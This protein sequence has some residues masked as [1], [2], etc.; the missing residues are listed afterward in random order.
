ME[1]S[2]SQRGETS[3]KQRG[4]RPSNAGSRERVTPLLGGVSI[5]SYLEGRL[6][7]GKNLG[8]VGSGEPRQGG[9]PRHRGE[10]RV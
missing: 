5:S 2:G 9:G 6:E 8:R 10:N 1:A 7:R 3:R 4:E